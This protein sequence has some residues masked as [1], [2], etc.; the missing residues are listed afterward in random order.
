MISF[1]SILVLIRLYENLMRGLHLKTAGTTWLEELIGLASAGGDGLDIAKKVYVEALSRF[2]E[3]CGPY[4]AVV[5]IDK[6]Q[7]P[8]AEVISEWTGE[9]FAY[10]LRH[11]LACGKYNLNLRQLLH[12]G[13]KVAAEMG[14]VYLD[15]LGKYEGI[16]A[17]N[18]RG[19]IF[20]RHIKPVF[21]D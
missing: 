10:A 16:I 4:A 12:V 17:E 21:M 5:D 20:D 19:N 1:R 9:G 15:A 13:Y 14:T 11:D 8:S 6:G 18:V 3:L 2:D 7:L